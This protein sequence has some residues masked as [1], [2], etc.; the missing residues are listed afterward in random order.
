MKPIVFNLNINRHKPQTIRFKNSPCPFCNKEELTDILEQDGNII[1]LMNKYPVLEDTW[2]TVIIESDDCNGEFST[3]PVEEVAK[4]LEFSIERWLRVIAGN[5]FQSVALYKNFGPNSGGSIRHPHSQI[6]GFERL[7]YCDKISKEHFT[8]S[9]LAHKDNIELTFS[10]K[11]LVGFLEFNCILQNGFSPYTL[12]Q[13]IQGVLQF[14]FHK[15]AH[16]DSYNIYFYKL[17]DDN[18]YIKILP[19]F[20]ASPLYLGYGINQ[21]VSTTAHEDIAE[22][23]KAFIIPKI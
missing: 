5:N 16:L 13:F 21:I 1:W 23:I 14:L 22:E 10:K 4:I 9:V 3:M 15:F 2:Q 19:R 18:I 17:N 12:A 11:P 6:V 20:V 7:N 8:G